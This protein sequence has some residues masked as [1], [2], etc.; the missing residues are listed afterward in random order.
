MPHK[1]PEVRRAYFAA[2]HVKNRDRILK[3]HADYYAKNAKEV[4]RKRVIYVAN[5]KE[6]VAAYLFV[7]SRTHRK[8][9]NAQAVANYAANIEEKRRKKREY[10]QANPHI[11]NARQAR[12]RARKAK[13]PLN[14]LT[15]EQWA[16]LQDTF[17]HRCAYCTK[18]CKGKLTKDHIIPLSQGGS[19]T[20]GNIVPACRSCNS[21]KYVGPPL[22]PVQP[23]L[24]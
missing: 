19:H 18:R 10:V 14:D 21:K 20:L 1:D 11:E 5:H 6:A 9:L 16:T 7:Y 4:Y 13:T 17:Q 22:K 23:L 2:Y 24:L 3:Q 12:R 8:K 15:A